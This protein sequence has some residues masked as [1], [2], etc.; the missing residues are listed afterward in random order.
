MTHAFS[1]FPR[2]WDSVSNKT[3]DATIL[4]FFKESEELHTHKLKSLFYTFLV[5][6]LGHIFVVY[7]SDNLVQ[8]FPDVEE[9]L[10]RH[11]HLLRFSLSKTLHI[12]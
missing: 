8:H 9:S 5:H 10:D 4:I 11:P 12:L 2:F 3:I 6:P 7:Y 1:T